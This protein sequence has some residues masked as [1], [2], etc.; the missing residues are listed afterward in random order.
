MYRFPTRYVAAFCVTLITFTLLVVVGW[1]LRSCVVF[2]AHVCCWSRYA[3]TTRTGLVCGCSFGS[4]RYGY[5]GYFTHTRLLRLRYHYVGLRWIY[6]YVCYVLRL[7]FALLTA[8]PFHALFVARLFWLFCCLDFAVTHFA[9]CRV[10]LSTRFIPRVC[11]LRYHVDLPVGFYVPVTF[12]C[13]V[14][15]NTF[16]LPRLHICCCHVVAFYGCCHTFRYVAAL[17]LDAVRCV[18]RLPGYGCVTVVVGS[19][20]L[21]FTTFGYV[22]ARLLHGC[23]YGTPYRTGCSGCRCLLHVAGCLRLLRLLRILFPVPTRLLRSARCYVRLLRCPVV[24]TVTLP[25]LLRLRFSYVTFVSRQF[26]VVVRY[27]FMRLRIALRTPVYTYVAFTFVPRLP[28]TVP[29]YRS[30]RLLLPLR[31]RL[32]TM[33]LPGLVVFVGYVCSVTVAR[34][35]RLLLPTHITRDVYHVPVCCC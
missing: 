3:F 10:H 16:R 7:D 17:R 8:F 28:F 34:S 6:V 15:L 19:L 12:R 13:Y 35:T 31:L 32:F 29:G 11:P 30:T 22:V 5:V 21:R 27:P 18:L 33:R 4:P 24:V 9:R 23:G 20:R 1:L 25:F 14:W 2:I 26:C